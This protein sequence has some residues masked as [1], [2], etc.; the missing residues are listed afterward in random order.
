MLIIL[1]PTTFQLIEIL[2]NLE[3]YINEIL[4]MVNYREES[5]AAQLFLI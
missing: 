1:M 5:V 3:Q 2:S 4:L